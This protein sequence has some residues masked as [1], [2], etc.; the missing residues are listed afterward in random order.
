[1]KKNIIETIIGFI[2]ITI[3]V[4][5][6]AFV[7]SSA[8]KTRIARATYQVYANFQNVDGIVSGSDIMISGIKVG[9]VSEVNLDKQTYQAVVKMQLDDN[10]KIP[11]DS[12]ASI[13]SSGLLGGNKFIAIDPGA[14]DFML[15]NG[16]QIIN[17]ASAVNL[18][19]LIGKFMYSMGNKSPK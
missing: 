14:E 19:S 7:Y 2:V 12:K 6:V 10:I 15:K 16:D 18:E 9:K 3:T 1:M 11:S 4:F 17:T 5:F 8:T 13:S